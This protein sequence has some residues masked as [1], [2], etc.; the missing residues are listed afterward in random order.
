LAVLFGLFGCTSGTDVEFAL[1][2]GTLLPVLPS[3]ITGT[4]AAVTQFGRT[5]TSMEIR[6]GEAGVLYG[7]RINSGTCQ[8]E[9]AIQGGLAAYPLLEADE[10]GIATENAILSTVF[11]SGSPYAARVYRPLEGGAQE[12]LACGTLE[13]MT[14]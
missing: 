7:W 3:T 12:I 9:G 5:E 6:Q 13:E 11:R 14:S 1:W 8:T 4:A 2:E 10:T